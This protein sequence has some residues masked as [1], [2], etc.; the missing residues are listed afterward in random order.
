MLR[1]LKR[2]ALVALLVGF[3]AMVPFMDM[4]LLFH[5]PFQNQPM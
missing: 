2:L 5:P 3:G 1:W 4:E